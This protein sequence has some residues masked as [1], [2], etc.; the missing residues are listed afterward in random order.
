MFGLA[1]SGSVSQGLDCCCCCY[2]CCRL[3]N[4]PGHSKAY[5]LYCASCFLMALGLMLVG[6]K[7][8]ACRWQTWPK[9]CC[10][11]AAFFVPSSFPQ[12][13]LPTF[14]QITRLIFFVRLLVAFPGTLKMLLYLRGTRSL[15]GATLVEV[16]CSPKRLRIR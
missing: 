12:L 11:P 10:W 3:M 2:Y 13:P 15:I 9:G 16:D 4:R 1:C 7:E 8:L 6:W 14:D 5:T